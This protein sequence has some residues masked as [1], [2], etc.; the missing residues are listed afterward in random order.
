[1]EGKKKTAHE[2]RS[3]RGILSVFRTNKL[4]TLQLT[5][6]QMLHPLIGP[7]H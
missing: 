5:R 3:I 6:S 4:L 2:T 1:M 7:D